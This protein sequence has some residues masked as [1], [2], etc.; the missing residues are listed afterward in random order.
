[1]REIR[2]YFWLAIGVIGVHLLLVALLV[3]GSG[4][5]MTG[6]LFRAPAG[7]LLLY[8]AAWIG[9]FLSHAFW[10][11]GLLTRWEKQCWERCYAGSAYQGS[12]LGHYFPFLSAFLNR[13]G[14]LLIAAGGIAGALLRCLHGL[15]IGHP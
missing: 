4:A 3:I 2:L 1:M 8:M 13:L 5:L 12:F 9:V 15:W 6:A 10:R 14:A 11:E 7:W